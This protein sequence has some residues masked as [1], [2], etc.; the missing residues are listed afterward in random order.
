M[1]L[2]RRSN[3]GIFDRQKCKLLK[4]LL[5]RECALKPL[6]ISWQSRLDTVH[7]VVNPGTILTKA[8][9]RAILLEIAKILDSLGIVGPVI[10]HAKKLCRTSGNVNLIGMSRLHDKF[11][12]IG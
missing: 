4:L 6:G 9:K 8:T 11:I 1:G 12:Q 5:D 3:N 10:L 7:Y 2:K